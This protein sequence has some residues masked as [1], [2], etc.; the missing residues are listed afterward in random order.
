MNLVDYR[1]SVVAAAAILAAFDE[2]LTQDLA[3]FKLRIISLR[4]SL[5]T[6]SFKLFYWNFSQTFIFWNLCQFNIS[7]RKVRREWK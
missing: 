4:G 5:E 1:P 3:E 2:R 6:V 7:I